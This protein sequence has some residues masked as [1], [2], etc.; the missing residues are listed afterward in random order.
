M[1]AYSKRLL[2]P[3]KGQVQIVE[4]ELG[5]AITMDGH[6]WEVQF[7]SPL[8]ESDAERQ[9]GHSPAVT[10]KMVRVAHI[11][12][13]KLILLPWPNF[14]DPNQVEQ[15]VNELAAYVANA[16]LP[17][18]AN[19]LYEYWLLDET[20]RSPLALI[21]SCH[22]AEQMASFPVRP[23]WT[24]L[25]SSMMKI[26]P[27]EDEVQRASAPVNYR[28]ERLVEERAGRNPR[29]AWINRQRQDERYQFPPCLVSEDWP[30]QE[31]NQLCQ[32]YIERQAPR[33][34][35]LQG[36]DEETRRR[37]EL[38]ARKYPL[39]VAAFYPLYPAVVDEKLMK[40][41]RVEARLRGVTESV[42]G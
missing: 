42:N 31:Q 6:N 20:D 14:L 41:I 28:L 19:D 5:R 32:R 4:S 21:F 40:A 38:A 17:F 35:M 1:Q 24:A 39:E 12:D 2:S 29:A 15:C 8:Y 33:L 27:T 11:R 23:E 18:P 25:P 22:E 3:Y 34:L 7:I 13:H 9:H 10:H 16:T 26:E 36:L 30:D 37:L